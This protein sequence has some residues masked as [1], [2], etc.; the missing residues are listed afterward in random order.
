MIRLKDIL[1][2][3]TENRVNLMKLEALMEKMIPEMTKVQNTK[4]TQLCTE[5]HEMVG[6]FNTLPYT[7]HNADEWTVLRIALMAK[8]MEVKTEAEKMVDS[9]KVDVKPFIKAL[10]EIL[11]S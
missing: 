11:V 2:E 4:I 1:M 8:L 7:V 5:V 6:K 10:D 9:D 3:N